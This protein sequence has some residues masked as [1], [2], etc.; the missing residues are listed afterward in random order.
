VTIQVPTPGTGV[1]YCHDPLVFNNGGNPPQLLQVTSSAQCD[2][3]FRVGSNRPTWLIDLDYKP[4]PDILIYAK[5][6]RGYRQGGINS[7]NLGIETWGPEKVD[8]FE[9]GAK[10]SFHGAISGYFNFAGFYN[11]FTG[12]QLSVTAYPN[13]NYSQ[14]IGPAQGIVNA[15]KSRIWGFEVDASVSPFAGFRLDVGYTYLNTKLISFT[16]PPPNP[17]YLPFTPGEAPG[18]PLSLSPKNRVTVTGTY[19]L[20]LDESV[21][22]ISF[23][24][25][26]THTDANRAVADSSS[27]YVAP[28]N[29][30]GGS[31]GF[32]ILSASNLL[33]LNANWNSVMGEPVDLS[34]FMTNVTNEKRITFPS[35]S[36]PVDGGDGGHLNAPRMY[37]FRLKIHFGD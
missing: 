23:G 12:Q 4:T 35:Q 24:A 21:G 9:G 30:F 34:F 18:G 32:A 20:P 3:V 11:N 17:I 2:N 33:N 26:F 16:Q 13:A 7:N 8:T 22:K 10:T 37:G 15:G 31:P 14:L 27:P 6:A 28:L 29:G 1:L 25:T 36:L 5:W 19:T